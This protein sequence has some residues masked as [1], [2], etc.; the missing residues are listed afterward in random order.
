MFSEYDKINQEIDRKAQEEKAKRNFTE[1]QKQQHHHYQQNGTKPTPSPTTSTAE[2]A[3]AASSV[4]GQ[5]PQQSSS[6]ASRDEAL[7]RFLQS[8]H[9]EREIDEFEAR[10]KLEIAK[11][12]GGGAN[13]GLSRSDAMRFNMNKDINPQSWRSFGFAKGLFT[14]SLA[15]VGFAIYY[16]TGMWQREED[17]LVCT[18]C[19][20][21][22]EIAE[23]IYFGKASKKD[24]KD[25]KVGR[26]MP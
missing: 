12:Q 10:I 15:F 3:A 14:C 26:M 13:S 19:A 7:K 8:S 11:A 18:N 9:K 5:Q 6:A 4:G 22:K 24:D 2:A 23:E 1:A 17:L 25:Q 21:Q 16:Q 20:R